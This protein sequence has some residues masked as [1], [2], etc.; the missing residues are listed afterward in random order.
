[1][2]PTKTIRVVIANRP[3]VMREAVLA[4]LG[5]QPDVEIVTEVASESEMEKV[6][7]QT[8]PDVLIVA[9]RRSDR[10]PDA[11]Y[12][13]LQNHPFLKIIGIAPD[14]DSTLFY[15]ASLNIQFHRLESSR[16]SILNA[17]RRSG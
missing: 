9:L 7:E 3:K 2:K 16:E 10:L 13:I 17:L 5:D 6:I 15:W 14:R 12:S 4:V 8:N 1:M 11:C